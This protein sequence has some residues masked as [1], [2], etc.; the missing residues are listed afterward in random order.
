MEVTVSSKPILTAEDLGREYYGGVNR[1]A[2]HARLNREP[3]T[4]P[5]SFKIGRARRWRRETV[6]RWFAEQEARQNRPNR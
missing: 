2:I 3:D 1:E 6:E 5:P 4:L